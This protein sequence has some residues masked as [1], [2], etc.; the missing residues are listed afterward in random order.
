MLQTLPERKAHWGGFD[1]WLIYFYVI[2]GMRMSQNG[3]PAT[4]DIPSPSRDLDARLNEIRKIVEEVRKDPKTWE[5]IIPWATGLEARNA[6]APIWK[7]F[8]AANEA[9][10]NEWQR[11]REDKVISAPLDERRVRA[12]G[13]AALKGWQDRSWMTLIL[14]QMAGREDLTWQTEA[15]GRRVYELQPKQFF[16]DIDDTA[17][18]PLGYFQGTALGDTVSEDLLSTIIKV[19][20]DQVDSEIG[21][22]YKRTSDIVASMS[23]ANASL[24]VFVVGDLSL[25][26]QYT[27]KPDFVPQW[28]QQ[29]PRFSFHEYI[30]DIN[31]IPCFFEFDQHRSEV[32]VCDLSKI[33]TLQ[34]YMP[35]DNNVNGPL[36]KVTP[37]SIEEASRLLTEQPALGKDTD[38]N[39]LP[40]DEAIRHLQLHVLIL[41]EVRYDLKVIDQSAARKVTIR[42]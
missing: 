19:A 24:A 42:P 35:T 5:P 22:V 1:Q 33:G 16:I 25:E 23:T 2:A 20:I 17:L 37:I 31:G 7:Y 36:V 40:G 11:R 3:N 30:G 38:G 29:S 12:F 15:K 32:I 4:S 8:I 18:G 39:Q 14:T 28:Q 34:W 27:D 21:S 26:R 6:E 41:V 10:V 9:A 13:E